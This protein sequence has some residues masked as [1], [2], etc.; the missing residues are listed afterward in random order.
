VKATIQKQRRVDGVTSI[1][2]EHT[3]TGFQLQITEGPGGFIVHSTQGV[4]MEHYSQ[5]TYQLLP[6][7]KYDEHE[8][9]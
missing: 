3:E 1:T 4:R 7:R 8:I 5:N 9:Q 6:E 2:L